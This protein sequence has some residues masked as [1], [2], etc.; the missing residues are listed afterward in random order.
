M[1]PVKVIPFDRDPKRETSQRYP[2]DIEGCENTTRE[3]KPFCPDHID[4]LPEVSRIK[5]RLAAV[6]DEITLVKRYGA[7]AVDVDGFTA[8]EILHYLDQYGGRTIARMARDFG[9]E[10][11]VMGYYVR[12]LKRKKLVKTKPSRRDGTLVALPTQEF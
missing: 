11:E 2:C 3:G 4:H 5:Q 6:E 10:A 1:D 7:H 9:M 8:H 12:K